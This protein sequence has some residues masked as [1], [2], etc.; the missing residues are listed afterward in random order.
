LGPPGK[1]SRAGTTSEPSLGADRYE[2]RETAGQELR[3]GGGEAGWQPVDVVVEVV[4]AAGGMSQEL[5][6]QAVHVG[7][8]VGWDGLASLARL[9]GRRSAAPP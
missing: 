8:E 4:A 3:G 7:G 2:G 9:A 5:P 1:P 6:A